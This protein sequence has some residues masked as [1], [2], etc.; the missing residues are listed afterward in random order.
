MKPRTTDAAGVRFRVFREDAA[1]SCALQLIDIHLKN[2]DQLPCCGITSSGHPGRLAK[3][4][5]MTENF[6]YGVRAKAL[7]GPDG[8]P[9]GHIE[10]LPGEFAWR[11]VNAA[12]Y[13]FIHCVWNHDRK[14]QHLG[15]GAA[16]LEACI[17]DAKKEGMQG[18]AAITRQGPW[19]ADS[20]L[21]LRNGFQ[22]VDA[23]PP[24]YQL[25]ARKFTASAANPSFTGDWERK[26]ARYGQGLTLI[27]CGQCPYAVKFADEIARTA[28]DE[29]DIEPCQVEL[30]SWREAQDAPTPYA[31]FALIH[32]G[33]LLA[34]HPISRT[35]F[36]NIMNGLSG[37]QTI[38]KPRR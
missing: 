18:V 19:L 9:Y 16:M 27:R 1:A 13:M 29:Y 32:Q 7:M 14:R 21:Y 38:G 11:G 12:G 3:H 2:L 10:Y 30:T 33:R 23:A 34:D 26:L 31:V 15:R 4:R 6:R 5:W 17:R 25:L 22:P 36:R 28:R 20:R 35:R 24:D 37:R 8:K